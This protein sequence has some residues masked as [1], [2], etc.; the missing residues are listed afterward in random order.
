MTKVLPD[1]NL[2]TRKQVSVMH[3]AHRIP[4]ALP[5]SGGLP[6]RTIDAL[7]RR[8]QTFSVGPHSKV[9]ISD[10][11]QIA[12]VDPNSPIERR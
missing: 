11:L 2:A 6:L 12:K 5:Y 4:Y 1:L 8:P 10:R 7:F 3:P 9:V